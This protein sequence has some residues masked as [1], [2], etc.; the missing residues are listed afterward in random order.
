MPV[1]YAPTRIPVKKLTA[2]NGFSKTLAPLGVVT[3]AGSLAVQLF[4][5]S[6]QSTVLFV[7]LLVVLLL[8]EL[9]VL[10][11]VVFVVL[12]LVV[13]LVVFVVVLVVLAVK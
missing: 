7:V 2:F 4:A 5:G 3:G 9:L 6:V 12:L 13:L 11:L 8:V 10:L 1:S